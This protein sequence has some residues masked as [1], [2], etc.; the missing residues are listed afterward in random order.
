LKVSQAN[1]NVTKA[2]YSKR[3]KIQ[4]ESRPIFQGHLG[5]NMEAEPFDVRNLH[6]CK[7]EFLRAC[8]YWSLT[9]D[10]NFIS[11]S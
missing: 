4:L 10:G 8:F 9:S 5:D 2:S 7:D 6:P 11:A 1:H 3:I